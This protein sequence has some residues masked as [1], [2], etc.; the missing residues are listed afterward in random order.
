MSKKERSIARHRG[1]IFC[2]LG[3][4]AVILIFLMGFWL[5]LPP[6][7]H[8]Q[9]T[10][11]ALSFDGDDDYGVVEVNK[12]FTE[13]TIQLWVYSK[14]FNAPR[15]TYATWLRGV[16]HGDQ[17]PPSDGFIKRAESRFLFYQNK[18]DWRYWGFFAT[19]APNNGI[20][21]LLL[22]NSHGT[23]MIPTITTSFS[24]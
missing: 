8:A 21:W 4:V 17:K 16:Y 10:L 22:L 14:S 12:E 11:Y 18:F 24:I 3:H 23:V 1:Q 13:G 6:S 2:A 5:I 9:S 19:L 15:E 7:V 20:T